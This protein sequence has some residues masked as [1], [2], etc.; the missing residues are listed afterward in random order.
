MEMDI[1]RRSNHLIPKYS[2]K[3]DNS[4]QLSHTTNNNIMRSLEKNNF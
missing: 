3:K 1:D 2:D 4:K